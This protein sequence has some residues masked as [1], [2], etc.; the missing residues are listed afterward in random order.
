MILKPE[1][2]PAAVLRKYLDTSGASIP[3]DVYRAISISITLL[4][5]RELLAEESA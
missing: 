4:E 2:R 1:D 3:P 5:E